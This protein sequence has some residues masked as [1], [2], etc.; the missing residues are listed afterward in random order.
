MVARQAHNLEVARSNPASATK[1][2]DKAPVD[3]AFFIS[4]TTELGQKSEKYVEPVGDSAGFSPTKKMAL[5]KNFQNTSQIIGFT[6]PRLHTGKS[7]Y[8]DFFAYDPLSDGM[9]RKKYMLDRIKG[10]SERRKMAT[11]LVSNLTQR[12]IQGWSP[13]VKNDSTRHLTCL[14]EVLKSYRDYLS[15]L[16]VKGTLKHKTAYDYL[17]RV[18]TLENYTIDMDGRD[19]C[20]CC[21]SPSRGTLGERDVCAGRSDGVG[22]S[23]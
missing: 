7:W 6:L 20:Q 12:L 18:S 15:A 11:L 16:E 19:K 22:L 4:G 23:R 10:R 21:H 13:W 3:G 17:S 14:N 1:E 2:D 8:V 9:K 5:P